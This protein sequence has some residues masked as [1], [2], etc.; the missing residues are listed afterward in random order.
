[1][2]PCR[3]VSRLAANLSARS[4]SPT[5][6]HAL[7]SCPISSSIRRVALHGARAHRS[8]AGELESALST[9]AAAPARVQVCVCHARAPTARAAHLM[10]VPSNSVVS[11]HTSANEAPFDHW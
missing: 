2:M 7:S 5:T 9:R 1:M 10:M 4:V 8:A 11:L 3:I 6:L